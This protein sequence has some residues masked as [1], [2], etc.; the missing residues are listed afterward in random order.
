MLIVTL[1]DPPFATTATRYPTQVPGAEWI[2]SK[3]VSQSSKLGD[4]RTTAQVHPR[5]LTQKLAEK[6]DRIVNAQA[7]SIET[8][9]DG[10][11]LAVIAK[12][13][14][15]K[16]VKLDCSDV[17]VAA[18]P[19]SGQLMKKLFKGDAS[20]HI[21][22]FNIVGSRAHSVSLLHLAVHRYIQSGLTAFGSFQP[23]RLSSSHL[24]LFPQWPV[25]P[26]SEQGRTRPSPSY[27]VVQTGQATFAAR[28]ITLH[29]QNEQIK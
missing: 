20:V 4:E 23:F 17:V 29:Y 15:G 26:P 18:G 27:T 28:R 14:D 10:K 24:N 8:G 3:S 2:N 13:K 5:L 11:P 1:A 25:S 19:W 12:D 21:S 22:D 9:P 7:E 6:A 16:Q